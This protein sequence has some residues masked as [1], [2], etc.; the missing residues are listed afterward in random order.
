VIG[1]AALAAPFEPL[2]ILETTPTDR[3]TPAAPSP[4]RQSTSPSRRTTPPAPGQLKSGRIT[5]TQA[6]APDGS[7]SLV[8]P[9]GEAAH[10]AADRPAPPPSPPTLAAVSSGGVPMAGGVTLDAPLLNAQPNDGTPWG[11]A[12]GTGVAVGRASQKAA[13]ATA[14]FFSRLGKKIAGSF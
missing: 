11:A 10:D 5:R 13:V 4:V 3:V 8:M 14:G 6:A 1:L 12:A 9:A 2:A 7:P